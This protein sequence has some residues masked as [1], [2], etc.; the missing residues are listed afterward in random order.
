MRR[1]SF[2]HEHE[3]TEEPNEIF[4]DGAWQVNQPCTFVEILGSQHSERL[5]ET[6]YETGRECDARKHTRLDAS[7]VQH[8]ESGDEVQ[9][10]GLF[11]QDGPLPQELVEQLCYV[12][13]SFTEQTR[14]GAVETTDR[15]RVL[16]DEREEDW[17]DYEAVHVEVVL[18]ES[19][20]HERDDLAGTY[21]VTF[22]L[23]AVRIHE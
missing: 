10:E 5:D 21:S 17:G 14:Y 1:D 12:I 6:F 20:F 9:G 2:A 13:R 15:N 22:D 16:V 11:I 4:E 8:I 18:K 7:R 19:D 23:K 3:W